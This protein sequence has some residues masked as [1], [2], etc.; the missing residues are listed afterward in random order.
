MS[1]MRTSNEV[2]NGSSDERLLLHKRQLHQ[3]LITS[4]D[5]SAIGTLNEEELQVEVRRAAEELCRGSS[6]ILSL[7]ERERLVNEVLDET[8]GLGPLEPIM[9]DPLVTDIL[10]NGP[11]TI[12]VERR[13]KLE[14][15][16][17]VFNDDQHLLRIVQRIAGRIGRRRCAT[18][19]RQPCQR[20]HSA[21]GPRRRSCLHPPV[22]RP[23]VTDQRS[24]HLQSVVQGNGRVPRRVHRGTGQHGHFGWNWLGKNHAL[25]CL[26]QLH[27]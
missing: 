18:R 26:V 6:D 25:E 27:P 4:M 11:K 9:R 12:Y 17:V 22:R 10:V 7:S 21:S 15:S 20:R 13:G 2:A 19:R 16:G 23:A 8:F 14:R 3:Q 24:R 1:K 5:L